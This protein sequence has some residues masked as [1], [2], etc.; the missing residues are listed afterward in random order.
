MTVYVLFMYKKNII[1]YTKLNVCILHRIPPKNL[2]RNLYRNHASVALI[3][4]KDNPFEKV[5]Y[6]MSKR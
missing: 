5:K 6:F 4:S 3:T 2:L 1:M